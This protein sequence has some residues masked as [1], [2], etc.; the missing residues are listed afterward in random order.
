MLSGRAEQNITYHCRNS[1]AYADAQ[2]NN[3]RK[4][5][6]LLSSNDLELKAQKDETSTTNKFAYEAAYDGCKVSLA[7]SAPSK[8]R[9]FNCAEELMLCLLENGVDS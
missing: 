6:K 3:F 8:L 9:S 5:V 4:A 7:K 1:L 2:K